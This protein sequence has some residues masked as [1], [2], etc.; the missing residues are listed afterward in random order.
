TCTTYEIPQQIQL[1]SALIL[2]QPNSK[3]T[4]FNHSENVADNSRKDR[5]EKNLQR[6]QNGEITNNFK[7]LCPKPP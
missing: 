1:K 6:Y 7:D 5:K 2:F 3:K 4:N